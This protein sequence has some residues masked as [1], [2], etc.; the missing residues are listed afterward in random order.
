M[1]S[2]LTE[3]TM[4]KKIFILFIILFCFSISILSLITPKLRAEDH[5]SSHQKIL[6]K[7]YIMPRHYIKSEIPSFIH[8]MFQVTDLSGVGIQN[9]KKEYFDLYEDGK[10]ISP[11]ESALHIKKRE[12]IPYILKTV[13]M[14][15]NSMSVGSNLAQIKKSAVD[16]VDLKL[17]EQQIAVYKFSEAPVLVQDF[18]ADK[19]QLKSAIN[20][21]ELGFAT[22]DFYGAVISGV[23]EWE[24]T[25]SV[26]EIQQG[27]LIILTDGSDTQGSHTLYQALSA[28]DNK[29]V[30]TIGVGNEIEP[31]VLNQLG[32]AGFYSI[33]NFDDL[34]SKFIEIQNK[35]ILFANSFYWLN[36]LSP[37]RGD[38]NHTLKL[39][40]KDNQ[41]NSYVTG[42]F[43]SKN[44]FQCDEDFM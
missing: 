5:E 23:S 36:Y 21:I 24:D 39:M 15:D 7:S 37:K 31:D 16:L 17:P 20:S 3:S 9:L 34:S 12:E 14:L 43:N 11:T 2:N 1:I 19:S 38:K 44:F 40:I 8:I 32:N 26:S 27:F 42:N 13:L 18:T 33:N 4:L 35:M 10:S 41:N 30:Y 25:Y 6:A 22:T 29:M 28:R